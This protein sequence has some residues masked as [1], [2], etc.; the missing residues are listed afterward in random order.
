M[1]TSMKQYSI[2]NIGIIAELNDFRSHTKLYESEKSFLILLESLV[3]NGWSDSEIITIRK[4]YDSDELNKVSPFDP[5]VY[6]IKDGDKIKIG[7]KEIKFS[8]G[9]FMT[10]QESQPLE[11][12]VDRIN[13][14]G[15]KRLTLMPLVN[16][17]RSLIELPP[18][19]KVSV[20]EKI[21]G[22]FKTYDEFLQVLFID[23]WRENNIKSQGVEGTNWPSILNRATQIVELG[24]NQ[25][26]LRR[27]MF[28]GRGMAQKAFYAITCDRLYKTSICQ[29]VIDGKLDYA[30]FSNNTLGQFVKKIDREY[31]KTKTVKELKKCISDTLSGK[32][33]IKAMAKRKDLEGL[34]NNT[35]I[36]FIKILL[37]AILEND[38][39]AVMEKFI[40]EKTV[41]NEQTEEVLINLF[42]KEE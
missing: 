7:E 40:T 14:S 21:Y 4:P 2:A 19:Q 5:S 30:K 24:G 1:K 15:F 13:A 28:F 11:K 8:R 23:T 38:L 3:L 31:R 6:P 16:F 10:F 9:D 26:T 22:T 36:R 41:I 39:P 18:I 33:N 27:Q 12:K 35:S 20:V 37:T 17:F 42:G 29:E 25:E 32:K 34:R